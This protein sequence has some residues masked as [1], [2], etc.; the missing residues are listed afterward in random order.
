MVDGFRVHGL[1]IGTPSASDNYMESEIEKT[2]TLIEKLSKIVKTSPQNAY[3]CY[4]K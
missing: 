1:V 4:T 3:S 2:A